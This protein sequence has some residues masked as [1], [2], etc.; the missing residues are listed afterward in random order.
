MR[1]L[2]PLA[3]LALAG[4]R[5]PDAVTVGGG[6]TSPSGMAVLDRPGTL[7][8][9]SGTWYL[10]RLPVAVPEPALRENEMQE[11]AT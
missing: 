2:L 1:W 8:M 10:G 5:L 7:I 3:L 9:V 6:V 11:K 4:C